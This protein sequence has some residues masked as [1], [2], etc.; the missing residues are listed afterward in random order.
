M[1][2]SDSK[3]T[4]NL[5]SSSATLIVGVGSFVGYVLANRLHVLGRPVMRVEEYVSME[6]KPTREKWFYISS[7]HKE[8]Q[9]V[10]FVDLSNKR[11][12]QRLLYTNPSLRTL[13]YVV[14]VPNLDTSNHGLRGPP[15]F[16]FV[17]SNFIHL[18]HAVLCSKEESVGALRVLLVLPASD[19]K[20]DSK[21]KIELMELFKLVLLSYRSTFGINAN[22]IQITNCP[23]G[24]GCDS[25]D[26]IISLMDSTST[27]SAPVKT[28]SLFLSSPRAIRGVENIIF[29]TYITKRK[30]KRPHS[31]NHFQYLKGFFMTAMKH[32]AKMLIV[33]DEITP[34]FQSNI[35]SYYGN[36]QFIQYTGD[37]H[38]RTI[39][40][41]RFYIMFD[42]MLRHPEINQI[43][44]QDLRD[45]IFLEDPFKVMETMGNYFYV[46]TD[47]PFKPRILKHYKGCESTLLQR[48]GNQRL[49]PMLN[50]GTLGGTWETVLSFLVL[51]LRSFEEVFPPDKNCNM[52]A[53]DFVSHK[54][55]YDSIF[56]GYPFQGVM[57]VELAS[58]LGMAVRHKETMYDK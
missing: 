48:Y 8:N 14:S 4:I 5:P 7:L 33:H 55:L 40:D 46:G 3:R 39:N 13:V 56:S 36:I 42:Y 23:S 2:Q 21:I 19:W 52:D 20:Q 37:Y 44:L 10:S 9:S 12:V 47:I 41:G 22:V 11:T 1:Q 17:V 54:Y 31:A 30:F 26:D 51:L 38:H 25:V 29:S 50:A 35:I 57:E 53:V 49:Y 28:L 32:N 43:L 34:K 27:N 16:S 58:P 45:G 24:K 18:L 15:N 6:M